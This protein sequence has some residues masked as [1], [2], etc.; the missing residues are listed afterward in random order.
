MKGY[1]ESEIFSVHDVELL[2]RA[3]ALVAACPARIGSGEDDW[4]RCHELARAV[5]RRLGLQ[6]CDGWFGLIDHTWLWLGAF[7]TRSPW[8]S[9]IPAVLDVYV[10]GALPQVQIIDVSRS[11]LPFNYRRGPERTDIREDVLQ[12]LL[13]YMNEV[14][15]P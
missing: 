12:Q 15:C 11:S 5:G 7:D 13:V 2:E 4:V 3:R 10:P 8:R 9:D 6:H 14:E 1:T